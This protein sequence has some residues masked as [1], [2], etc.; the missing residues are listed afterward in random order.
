MIPFLWG[1]P[2]RGSWVM[3][4]LLTILLDKSFDPLYKSPMAQVSC[5]LWEHWDLWLP[6]LPQ[7]TVICL[8]SYVWVCPVLFPIYCPLLLPISC[9]FQWGQGALPTT[10]DACQRELFAWICWSHRYACLRFFP[11]MIG[12][13][14]KNKAGSP[15]Q[16]CCPCC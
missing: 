11:D 3:S 16:Q 9:A 15:P 13:P 7:A 4:A 2:E 8:C 14:S 10:L 1:C 6:W 5:L 12:Y